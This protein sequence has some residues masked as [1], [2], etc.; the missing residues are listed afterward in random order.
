MESRVA[1]IGIIVDDPSS[2]EQLNGILHEYAEIILARMG[3]PYREKG[4]NIIS[5]VVDAPQDE[6]SA[7]SGK[8]GALSGVSVKTAYSSVITTAE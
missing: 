7:L 4:V 2:V 8:I 5:V 1:V 6:I 3:F